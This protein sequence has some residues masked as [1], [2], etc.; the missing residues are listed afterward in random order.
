VAMD[1]AW[2]MV[3]AVFVL[4]ALLRAKHHNWTG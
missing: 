1:A 3:T 2:I 4:G